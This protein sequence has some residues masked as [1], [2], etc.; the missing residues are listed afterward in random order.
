[1]EIDSRLPGKN[2]FLPFWIAKLT[3][4]LFKVAV[5]GVETDAVKVTQDVIPAR[6]SRHCDENL[7]S[8]SRCE[9]VVG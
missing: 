3:K 8:A 7:G 9:G 1:M 2:C 4:R 6:C 5:R